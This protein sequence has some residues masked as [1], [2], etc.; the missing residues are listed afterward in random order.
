MKMSLLPAVV[1]ITM[2]VVSGCRERPRHKRA[3]V[4][5]D[6]QFAIAGESA[7]AL[8]ALPQFDCSLEN[9]RTVS[10]NS[11]HPGEIPNSWK[12]EKGETYEV[13]GFAINRAQG[14]VPRAIRLVLI[15]KSVYS[16]AAETGVGRPDVAQY[17]AS[18]SFLR[19]GYSSEVAFD[20]VPVGDYQ[21]VVT[22]TEGS[23][24]LVCRTFQTI[25]IR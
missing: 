14:S 25:S 11:S 4:E 2:I 16:V 6:R 13:S 23:R 18:G 3:I 19:A 5:S 9:V 24:A 10:N 22:Q 12:V 15:G 8:L 21:V 20:D 1:A 17:F 7:E